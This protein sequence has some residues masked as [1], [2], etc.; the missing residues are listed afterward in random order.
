MIPSAA[1]DET[2]TLPMRHAQA[3]KRA[4]L[5]TLLGLLASIPALIATAHAQAPGYAARPEVRAFIT[6]LVTSEDFDGA[7]LRRVFTQARYQPK[8]I[9]AMSRPLIAPPRWHEYAPQFVNPAR[10][11]AGV[12]FWRENAVVLARAQEEFGVPAEVIVAIIGVETFYGRNTG[13]Y[14]VFDALVTLAFDYPRRADFF[15][16]ELKQFL[17]LMREQGVSPLAPKGSYAGAL[18]L[19]QFMPGSIRAYAVDYDGDGRIDLTND[20]V[21]AVGSV[22]NFLAHHG[23]QPG[24]PV[25]EAVRIETE[26]QD[27]ILRTL[28][29]G[30]AERRSIIAWVR[31]GV[32]G[33]GIPGNV[34]PDPVGLLM[35]ED[36]GG[37]SY[38]MV[39]NNWYV[40]TRY[41]RSRLY[42][43]A[44]WA[45]AGALKAAST[46]AV[47]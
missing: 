1:S 30:I 46:A 6:E 10:V 2:E 22:A 25:M 8:V 36:A 26:T 41:N 17:L 11:G 24:Q 4:T 47:Q 28:D 19:P 13:S 23:W 43:S 9:A 29:G 42:A 44:V 40:L 37:P 35:L 15:T 18:G 33:F 38:W 27:F 7:A 31:D 45:L 12:A 20:T 14:R 5:R 16:S 21:D 34:A 39:F 3:L 32:T